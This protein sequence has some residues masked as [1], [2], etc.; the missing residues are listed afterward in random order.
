MNLIQIDPAYLLC[1]TAYGYGL[2][3]TLFY[4]LFSQLQVYKTRVDMISAL[5][6]I[7][8]GAVSLDGGI[9]RKTGIFTLGSRY[10]SDNFITS[11]DLYCFF[12]VL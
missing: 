4:S 1:V 10:G 11:F 2:R 6:C 5:P 7:T 3:E 8:D 9:L 12:T